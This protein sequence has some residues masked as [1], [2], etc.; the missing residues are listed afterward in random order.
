MIPPHQTPIAIF[1]ANLDSFY[2]SD[3]DGI[4]VGSRPKLV[5]GS[6]LKC[7]LVQPL[8]KYISTSDGIFEIQNL[9]KDGSELTV[10]PYVGPTASIEVVAP[11]KYAGQI[12]LTSDVGLNVTISV[13]AEG[14][15]ES[16]T[17]IPGGY[18][19]LAASLFPPYLVDQQVAVMIISGPGMPALQVEA[20]EK[21][22][23]SLSGPKSLE[24][25]AALI[26]GN[27]VN[28]KPESVRFKGSLGETYNFGFD[29][30]EVYLNV[31]GKSMCL[32]K[33]EY[34]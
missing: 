34:G 22:I 4:I 13:H 3:E 7:P 21:Q 15:R 6:P 8:S 33:M 28:I 14:E 25:Q 18:T 23:L 31:D 16:A 9:A 20:G 19:I 32:G 2:T 11:Q 29:K 1:D 5:D 10:L 24:F 17:V 30:L 12:I 27:K 26:A